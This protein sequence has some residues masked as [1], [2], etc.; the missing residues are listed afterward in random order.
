MSLFQIPERVVLELTWCR[1]IARILQSS[2]QLQTQFDI[3]QSIWAGLT[4]EADRLETA[5]DNA[6]KGWIGAAIHQA[7]D[8]DN[9][10]MGFAD[11]GHALACCC[12][13]LAS[14]APDD[15]HNKCVLSVDL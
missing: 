1:T 10:Y 4:E 11:H 13:K 2:H 8:R 5:P 6:L 3:L 7:V 9:N 12:K 15:I 14:V